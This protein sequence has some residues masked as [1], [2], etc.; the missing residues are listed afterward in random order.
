MRF[1]FVLLVIAGAVWLVYDSPSLPGH[2]AL[3]QQWDSLQKTVASSPFSFMTSTDNVGATRSLAERVLGPLDA[4]TSSDGEETDPEKIIADIRSNLASS[5][6]PSTAN[7]NAALN[8]IHQAWEERKNSITM[9]KPAPQTSVLDNIPMGWRGVRQ[10]DK[11]FDR[12]EVNQKQR[13][14]FWAQ[15]TANQWQRRSAMYRQR[16]EQLLGG[17]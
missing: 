15:A 14:S 9:T 6:S 16:I 13:S 11:V 7:I 17:Q 2:T 3:V 10:P 12:Q 4:G 5:Q 8:L 1:L